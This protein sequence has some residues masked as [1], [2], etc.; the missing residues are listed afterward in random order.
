MDRI[1]HR[2]LVGLLGAAVLFALPGCTLLQ[3]INPPQSSQSKLYLFVQ[4]A[5]SG[6]FTPVNAAAGTFKLTLQNVSPKVLYFTDRPYRE[7]GSTSVESYIEE[8]FEDGLESPNAALVFEQNP[9]SEQITIALELTEPDYNATANTLSYLV[10]PLDDVSDGL[11]HMSF[12]ELETVPSQFGTIELFIDT[13]DY[14]TGNTCEIYFEN[15]LEVGLTLDT[16]ALDPG[17]DSYKWKK[18]PKQTV[19]PKS[20]S[21]V[22]FRFDSNSKWKHG[23]FKYNFTVQNRSGYII[24]NFRCKQSNTAKFPDQEVTT[25]DYSPSDIVNCK[26]DNNGAFLK[27]K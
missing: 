18:A 20:Q 23:S 17:S 13:A 2:H 25:C 10:M 15:D 7:S 1:L 27:Y 11:I 22:Y 5:T 14:V 16:T 26:I 3:P 12:D 9:G 21:R 19:D 6:T 4:T 8:V 24:V